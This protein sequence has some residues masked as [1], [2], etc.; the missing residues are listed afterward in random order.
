[1]F[2]TFPIIALFALALFLLFNENSQNRYAMIVDR[3]DRYRRPEK[4][5]DDETRTKYARK[6]R[7]AIDDDENV[8][9]ENN[10]SSSGEASASRSTIVPI[11][12]SEFEEEG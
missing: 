7:V 1:M 9:T 10:Y 3:E 2:V 5:I 11:E 4:V 8:L 12:D 6:T